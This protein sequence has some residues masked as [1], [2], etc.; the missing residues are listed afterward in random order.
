MAQ[1]NRN[2]IVLARVRKMLAKMFAWRIKHDVPSL[3]S[4]GA[5]LVGQ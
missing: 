4:S 3:C 5:E 2:F 1:C